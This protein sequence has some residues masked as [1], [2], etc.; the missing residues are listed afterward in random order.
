MPATATATGGQVLP[1]RSEGAMPARPVARSAPP[2]LPVV[3]RLSQA[4]AG[5]AQPAVPA[6]EDEPE[7]PRIAL[8]MT[9]ADF[10]HLRP[11]VLFSKCAQP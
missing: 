11:S 1:S 6:P 3:L 8:E 7:P 4:R 2:R 5:R 10:Q 9:A